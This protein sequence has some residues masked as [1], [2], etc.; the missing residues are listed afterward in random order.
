MTLS[1][2]L[3]CHVSTP[4]LNDGEFLRLAATEDC[5]TYSQEQAS[6]PSARY[7]DQPMSW[8]TRLFG[9][10]GVTMVVLVIL[11]GTV[12]TWRTYHAPPPVTTI[13][14]FDVAPPAAPPEPP[15]EIPPGPEQVQ[16]KE[17]LSDPRPKIEPPE[18]RIA[19]E[20][21][22]TAPESVPDPSP[23]VKDTAAPEAK[24]VPPAPQMSNARPTWEGAVLAALDKFKRYPRDA[25]FRRQ[26]GVPYIRFVMDREGRVLSS[27]L[28]RSSGYRAL[29]NEAV[30]LPTRAAPLPPPPQ[31]VPG[32]T[33]ELVVPVEFF[34]SANR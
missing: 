9:M 19:S 26:Q 12:F 29:D 33:I 30:A 27:R 8:S 1:R 13:S 23:P 24:P 5:A 28:E 32:D 10:G 2:R 20:S 34:L 31:D 17:S 3:D 11:A 7:A 14:V 22:L 4:L 15:T 6:R 18:I 16:K 21:P 25:S